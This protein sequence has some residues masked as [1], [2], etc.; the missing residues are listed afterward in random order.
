V[1]AQ[2]RMEQQRRRNIARQRA[3]E[4]DIHH[5]KLMLDIENERRMVESVRMKEMRKRADLKNRVEEEIQRAEMRLVT[6]NERNRRQERLEAAFFK[7]FQ[8]WGMEEIQ[9]DKMK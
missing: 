2:E 3:L 7:D 1:S 8:H 4:E 9:N 5:E 6:E